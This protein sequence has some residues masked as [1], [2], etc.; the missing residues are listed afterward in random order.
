[1]KKNGANALRRKPARRRRQGTPQ[2]ATRHIPGYGAKSGN[3]S[4]GAVES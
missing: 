2:L 1:M 4:G 3:G